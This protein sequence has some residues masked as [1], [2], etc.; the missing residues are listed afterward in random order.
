MKDCLLSRIYLET[1][2]VVNTKL[3]LYLILTLGCN[4]VEFRNIEPVFGRI[5]PRHFEMCYCPICHI[6]FRHERINEI[7]NLN[8]RDIGI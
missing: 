7:N 3:L 8:S 1:L 2:H 5:L 6:H 4:F